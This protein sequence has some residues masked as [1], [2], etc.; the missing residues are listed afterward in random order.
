[1]EDED[2]ND[3]EEASGYEKS[4]VQGACL[5]L[6]SLILVVLPTRSG[7]VPAV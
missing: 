4:L 5:S 7:L 2:G 3:M 1:M 6:D